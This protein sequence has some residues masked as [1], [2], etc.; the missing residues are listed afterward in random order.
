M[1]NAV[2]DRSTTTEIQIEIARITEILVAKMDERLG[3]EHTEPT[4][5]GVMARYREEMQGR[6]GRTHRAYAIMYVA[7]AIQRPDRYR[8]EDEIVILGGSRFSQFKRQARATYRGLVR[9]ENI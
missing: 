4:V 7:Q 8:N 9:N 1:T 6:T 2:N 5:D 3:F